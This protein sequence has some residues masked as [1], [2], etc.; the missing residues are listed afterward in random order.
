MELLNKNYTNFDI[1]GNKLTDLIPVD[2][3]EICPFAFDGFGPGE[4]YCNCAS[5]CV[6]K[7]Y[8]CGCEAALSCCTTYLEQFSECILCPSAVSNPDKYVEEFDVTCQGAADFV[9]M[10]ILEFGT[11]FQCSEA[12]VVF[13]L[14]G[15]FCEGEEPENQATDDSATEDSV[16]RKL[17]GHS[18]GNSKLDGGEFR[19]NVAALIKSIAKGGTSGKYAT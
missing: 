4:V 10:N 19:G 6:T 12:K 5:D 18:L 11:E 16:V 17:A 15:C 13:G 9:K 8:L 2:G 1:T 3:T 14:V 7:D